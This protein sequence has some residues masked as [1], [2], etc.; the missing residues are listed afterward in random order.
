MSATHQNQSMTVSSLDLPD[1]DITSL[2]SSLDFYSTYNV[3]EWSS[4]SF[5]AAEWTNYCNEFV[6]PLAEESQDTTESNAQ[7]HEV[8]ASEVNKN[9][10]SD[11]AKESTIASSIVVDES[12]LFLFPVL[13]EAA[14][15]FVVSSIP[16]YQVD[17]D[18]GNNSLGSIVEY[19]SD[20]STGLSK[21]VSDYLPEAIAQPL[22][23]M[24]SK[25]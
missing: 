1:I 13:D 25:K 24:F 11:G 19:L 2:D 14:P 18:D 6:Q 5:H 3:E 22:K 16:L 12:G 10:E 4:T 7:L 9:A 15:R 17:D 23:W 8:I 21:V 20:E